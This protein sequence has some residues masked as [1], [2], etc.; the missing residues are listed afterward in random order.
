MINVGIIEADTNR[1]QELK[2][3]INL[4]QELVCTYTAASEQD[5]ISGLSACSLM[6][7]ILV[8][9]KTGEK[10]KAVINRIQ[11]LKH[12]L[13]EAEVIILSDLNEANVVLNALRAG[14]LGYLQQNFSLPQ[15]KEV[16]M[17]VAAGGAFISPTMARKITDYLRTEQEDGYHLTAREQEIVTCLTAGYSYKMIAAELLLSLDTVRFHLRNI[18]KKLQVNSKAEVIAKIL[19]KDLLPLL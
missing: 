7:I 9:I 19:R 18:Y 12:R 14:A 2:N 3:F 10:A 5:F 16:I 4:Q 11:M 8:S 13:P 17:S 1:R 15:L 6:L